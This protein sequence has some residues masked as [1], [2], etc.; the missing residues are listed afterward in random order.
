[1]SRLYT[2]FPTKHFRAKLKTRSLH[3]YYLQRLLLSLKNN[4]LL[5][6]IENST[7]ASMVLVGRDPTA[8]Q[9]KN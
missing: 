7:D 1:M 5:L 8:H 9:Q 4:F 3:N 6:Q 2:C